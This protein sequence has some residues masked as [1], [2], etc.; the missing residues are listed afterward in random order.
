MLTLYSFK[1]SSTVQCRSSNIAAPMLS[2]CE[3]VDYS[4][5]VKYK[6]I[7]LVIRDVMTNTFCTNTMSFR[8]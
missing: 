3:Q 8:Y 1:P 7:I 4:Q 2:L 6:L 5:F